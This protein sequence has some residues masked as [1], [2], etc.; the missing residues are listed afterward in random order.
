MTQERLRELLRERVADE[1]MPDF[2]DRAWQAARRLRRRHRLGAAAGVVAAT[3]LASGVAAVTGS[4]PPDPE[5]PGE[6][7]PLVS[8]PDATYRGVPVWWSPDQQQEQ[9]LPVVGS[10]L[11]AS[12]DL[13]ASRPLGAGELER[14]IAAFARGRSVVLVG[15][16]GEL[17]TVDLSRLQDVTKPDGYSYFPTGTA[18][19]SPHGEYLVFPQDGHLAVLTIRTHSWT[20]ID[21]GA[22]ST[23]YPVWTGER[24]LVLVSAPFGRSGPVVDV[25]DGVVGAEI[26]IAEPA[27]LFDGDAQ[28]YGPTKLAP[29][30]SS[31]A[32]SWGM[33]I[34]LPVSDRAG[35]R[36]EPEFLAVD[37]AALV[38]MNL[39]G[40]GQGSRYQQCCPVAGWL[41]E[42]TVVYESRQDRPVL[43]AW[44]QGTEQ[45]RLVS[46][47]RGSY[48]VASFAL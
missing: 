37:G 41:D 35:Y 11:P 10:P 31:Q 17:R 38:F 39:V 6:P 2:A 15:P 5:T 48:D 34:P 18:M 16:G 19:L 44:T 23:L 22:A 32:Q 30:E 36:S 26:A 40:D 14:A 8:T 42:R 13:D 9:E 25:P 45:F 43:V 46:R 27:P 47:M 7:A 24:T 12:I 3:V 4:N 29:A 1:Q 21:T 28:A 20:A 33:G